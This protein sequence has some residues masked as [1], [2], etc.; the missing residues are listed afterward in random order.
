MHGGRYEI[1][2]SCEGSSEVDRS[3]GFVIR[4]LWG[5]NTWNDCREANETYSEDDNRPTQILHTKPQVATRITRLGEACQC[6]ICT[7]KSRSPAFAYFAKARVFELP[8][9]T[10]HRG[11]PMLSATCAERVESENA[12]PTITG[13]AHPCARTLRKGWA[14]DSQSEAEQAALHARRAG[15]QVLDGESMRQLPAAYGHQFR[16]GITSREA[17]L[18]QGFLESAAV[19]FAG[20]FSLWLARDIPGMQ[21]AC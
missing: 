15:H 16:P 9:R 13:V 3:I 14:P 2:L 18:F 17:A 5:V 12:N 19:P 4:R 7:A 21:L 11:W 1:G 20:G 6:E 8:F 10:S